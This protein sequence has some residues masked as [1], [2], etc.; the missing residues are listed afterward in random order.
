MCSQVCGEGHSGGTDTQGSQFMCQC[1]LRQG[2]QPPPL[3]TVSSC[4]FF[5]FEGEGDHGLLVLLCLCL[6]VWK[7]SRFSLYKFQL[8]LLKQNELCVI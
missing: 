1:R 5:L 7:D 2:A 6:R 8:L 3:E 4:L